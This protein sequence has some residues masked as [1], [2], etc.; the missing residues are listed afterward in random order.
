MLKKFTVNLDI[1]QITS[2]NTIFV[3]NTDSNSFNL[4]LNI[5]ESAVAKN[6][7]GITTAYLDIMKPDGTIVSVLCTVSNAPG[8]VLTVTFTQATIALPGQYKAL[9]KITDS[10]AS[11]TNT[12]SFIFVVQ[13]GW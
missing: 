9:V 3:S 6:L 4:T 11:I 7:T 12:N 10:D 5:L 13:A 1:E 8:G 2:N